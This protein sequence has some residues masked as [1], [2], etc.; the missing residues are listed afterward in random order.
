MYNKTAAHVAFGFMFVGFN[1]LFFPMFLLGF[2]GMPR[3][4]FTYLP[5]F[6]SLH[7]LSTVGSWI[8]A[9]GILIVV[10]ALVHAVLKGGKA[11]KDPWGGGTLEWK[12]DTPPILE[13]FEEVPEVVAGPYEFTRE[14]TK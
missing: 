7:Q 4:Y 6:E 8:L 10:W 1:T 3:R 5:E 11:G 14:L 2:K 9:T 13:N 12:V